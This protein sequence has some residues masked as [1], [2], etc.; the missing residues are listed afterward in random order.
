M[1]RSPRSP[2][3]GGALTRCAAREA[4]WPS[5]RS[6]DRSRCGTVSRHDERGDTRS[7]KSSLR[8]IR[9]QKPRWNVGR[10]GNS[11]C[12]GTRE[13][14]TGAMKRPV[15]SGTQPLP[16][17]PPLHSVPRDQSL[18]TKNPSA[19]P[20]PVDKPH[21]RC[22][23]WLGHGLMSSPHKTELQPHQ[24]RNHRQRCQSR[25]NPTPHARV[26]DHRSERCESGGEDGEKCSYA[27]TEST[28]RYQSEC[29]TSNGGKAT[30]S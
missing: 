22:G 30:E 11:L 19:T 1:G 23:A 2:P 15:V 26:R 28:E 27:R 17:A 13:K 8:T 12:R 16:R 5:A 10:K 6:P 20:S 21:R 18:T 7:T 14:N 25:N 9:K 3:Q 29:A 4:P 24:N